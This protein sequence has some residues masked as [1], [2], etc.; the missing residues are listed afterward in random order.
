[1]SKILQRY[2]ERK[3]DVARAK[4]LLWNIEEGW[5]APDLRLNDARWGDVIALFRVLDRF[6]DENKK[7]LF[8]WA[9]QQMEEELEILRQQALKELSALNADTSA[10]TNEPPPRAVSDN[11][12]RLLLGREKFD[13]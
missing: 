11:S 12:P 6:L 3:E 2:I 4:K 1:M 10:L 9:T 13:G 5:K 7:Y 8:E